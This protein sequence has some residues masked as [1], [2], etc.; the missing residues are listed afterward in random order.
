LTIFLDWRWIR[1]A[2]RRLRR[3]MVAEAFGPWLLLSGE[4][5]YSVKSVDF[6][7]DRVF[8]KLKLP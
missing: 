4:N 7:N 8:F 6:S 1:M 3:F 5:Q 2:A